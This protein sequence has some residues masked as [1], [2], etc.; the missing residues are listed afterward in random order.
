[1]YC[2]ISPWSF[3]M[4]CN[5]LVSSD[6][7]FVIVDGIYTHVIM[8]ASLCTVNYEIMIAKFSCYTRLFPDNL[9]EK[10]DFKIY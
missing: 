1:M 5:G 7:C 2:F 9:I 10:N 8:Y 6:S 3:N 4:I